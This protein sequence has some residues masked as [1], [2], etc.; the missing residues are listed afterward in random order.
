MVERIEGFASEEQWK[1]AYQEIN[2]FEEE[3]ERWGAVIIKFWLHFS[4]DV[5]KRQAYTAPVTN[6]LYF[7]LKCLR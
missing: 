7:F 1:R 3:L 4:K 2:E 5:Y 6:T